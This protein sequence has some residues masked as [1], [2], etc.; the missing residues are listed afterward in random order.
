MPVDDFHPEYASW[1]ERWSRCRDFA[2]G[3]DA[4]K[5]KGSRYL[6]ALSGH[7][8]YSYSGYLRRAGFFGATGRVVSAMLGAAFARDPVVAGPDRLTAL[9]QN[10]DL[11]G[12]PLTAFARQIVEQQATVGRVGLMV[13]FSATA[14]RPYL[15]YYEAESVTNW[16]VEAL[17]NGERVLRLVV[18][19]ESEQHRD[20]DDRFKV[21]VKSRYRVLELVGPP[22]ALVF[23][24]QVWI[25]TDRSVYRANPESAFIPEG[26]PVTP[27]VRG[28]TFDRIPFWI[29]GAADLTPAVDKP[30]LLD[31]VN[32]N[33]HHY[34]GSA[35]HDHALHWASLPTP[36]VS[37]MPKTDTPTKLHVGGNQA[38]ML[39]EGGQAG[40][41]EVTG[42]G[43]AAQAARIKQLEEH[44]QALGTRLMRTEKAGVEAEGT[45]YMRQAIE[46]ATLGSIIQT[47][48]QGLNRALEVFSRWAV[49]DEPLTIEI[50]TQFAEAK[51]AMV[52]LSETMAAYDAGKIGWTELVDAMKRAGMVA[53]ETDAEE[54]RQR[55]ASD[56]PPQRPPEALA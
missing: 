56:P 1:I 11:Q 5:S 53:P 51:F 36:W 35:D 13:D 43:F 50:T 45:V 39:P 6:P 54:L 40:Y 47:A 21:G 52:A 30:P 19:K 20:E 48:N 17:P 33:W 44:M 9:A 23:T 25:Q 28:R 8:V 2:A 10:I 38:W 7:D 32:A 4:V 3:E 26:D 37:G 41:L 49:S 15:T 16:L 29:I 46:D 14:A 34:I 18:L 12:T 27:S 22:E 24:Q 55:I 31:L 42:A